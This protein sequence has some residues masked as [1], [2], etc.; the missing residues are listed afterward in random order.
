MATCSKCGAEKDARGIKAHE[1]HCG[2]GVAVLDGP[3]PF[4]PRSQRGRRQHAMDVPRALDQIRINPHNRASAD[5]TGAWAYYLDPSGA[6]IRDALILYPNGGIPEIDDKRRQ[7]K[8]GT[9][10]AYYRE[11]QRA[12][13]KEYLGPVLSAQAIKKLVETVYQ[14]REDEILFCEDEIVNCDY[15]IANADKPEI[16]DQARRRRNQFARRLENLQQ[17][18]DPEAMANELEE[19]ARAQE[20]A[21]LDPKL[22]RVMQRQIGEMTENMKLALARFQAGRSVEGGVSMSRP[23]GPSGLVDA[24]G[25]PF[26]DRD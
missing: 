14:N 3:R 26:L 7:G 16:R 9:N 8:F 20:M 22:L 18:L 2:G 5:A 25:A 17:D 4:E 10:A 1:Q 21:S 6:T 15:T 12:K 11:R 13:G 23:D 19:I 24:E